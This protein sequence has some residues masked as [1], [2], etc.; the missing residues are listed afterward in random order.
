MKE[1]K[2]EIFAELGF[3]VVLGRWNRERELVVLLGLW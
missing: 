3:V 1:R 2:S